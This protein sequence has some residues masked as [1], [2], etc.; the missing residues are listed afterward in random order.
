MDLLATKLLINSIKAGTSIIY[1]F[2]LL[3]IILS[4][5]PNSIF[6]FS[7]AFSFNRIKCTAASE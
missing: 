5:V 3:H 6:T 1:H 7:I 2:F 4:F